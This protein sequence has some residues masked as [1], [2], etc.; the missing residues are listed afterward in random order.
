MRTLSGAEPTDP[1]FDDIYDAFKHPRR[2]RVSLADPRPARR[3]RRSSPTCATARSDV[4]DASDARRRRPAARRRLRLRH[5]RAARASARRDPARHDPAH[6]RLRAP[7]CRRRRRADEHRDEPRGRSRARRADPRRHLRDRH[8]RRSVGLRQRTTGARGHGRA[9][10]H[11]HHAGHQP[12]VPGVRRRRWVRR[13]APVG[14]RGLG[15][16]SGSALVAPQFWRREAAARGRAGASAAPRISRSTSRCS[17]CAGTR[18]T[19]SRA[20]RGARLP[21]EDRVGDR[22]RR[23]RR[24]ST[25]T[26]GTPGR[27]ASARPTS[28][29][30]TPTRSASGACT[31]CS[32]TCGS[33][34]RP[35]SAAYP[36]FV[37]FPYRE[38]SEVFFGPDYKV[39]RGGSWATHPA[40]MRSSFRNWDY[41]IRRQ[42][43]SGFR[44]ARDA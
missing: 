19:R 3:A 26:S 29:A 30:R 18:P 42:I 35:T 9:V 24:P 28:R 44:C 25:P 11:R 40:A 23:A 6:G 38:Y 2:D 15:V 1:A 12:R 31:R 5:G 41:P 43:F 34:P 8:E 20:G 33:G 17:T 7:R 21:T 22:R 4:L 13:R 14:R 27:I 36:G 32:A 37:S 39:L 16:A 10:P